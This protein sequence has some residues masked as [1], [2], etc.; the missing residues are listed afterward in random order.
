MIVNGMVDKGCE[1]PRAR[2]NSLINNPTNIKNAMLKPTENSTTST[3]LLSFNLRILR[4]TN[5]GINER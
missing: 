2:Y 1:M 3:T 5:P 4:R